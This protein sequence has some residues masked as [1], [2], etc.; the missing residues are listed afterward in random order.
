MES[1][2]GWQAYIKWANSFNLR[3]EILKEIHKVN[4]KLLRENNKAF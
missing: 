1:Y 2:Q 3:K 4:Q